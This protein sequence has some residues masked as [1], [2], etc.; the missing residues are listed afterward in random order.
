MMRIY[1]GNLPSEISQKELERM[2]A[3][4]G[5]VTSAVVVPSRVARFGFVDMPSHADGL[6]AIEA[7]DGKTLFGQTIHVHEATAPVY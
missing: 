7:L 6:H 5:E 4:F 3:V 2:F 1:V